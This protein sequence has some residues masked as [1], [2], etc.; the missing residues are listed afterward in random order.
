MTK[1]MDWWIKEGR[2]RVNGM[3]WTM[4]MLECMYSHLTE[5]E[6]ELLSELARDV[7]TKKQS[8]RRFL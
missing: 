6:R 2:Y 4:E 5:N 8:I 3:E 1:A 7:L